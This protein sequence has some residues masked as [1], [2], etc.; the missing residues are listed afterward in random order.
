MGEMA[1]GVRSAELDFAFGLLSP[2]H[3]GIDASGLQQETI[4]SHR[5]SIIARAGHPLAAE[6]KASLAQLAEND[7]VILG[8]ERAMGPYFNE[9]F[10]SRGI[11]PPR[12]V[13]VARSIHLLKKILA[14]S[15]LISILATNAVTQEIARGEL[16]ILQNAEAAVLSETGFVSLERTFEAPAVKAMK[17]A[18]RDQCRVY[19]NGQ[20]PE[21]MKITA[22]STTRQRRKR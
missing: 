3:A 16:A 12:Q 9:T 19:F 18:L 15:D 6:R 2:P 10:I 8:P 7:W 20:S 5:T 14:G 17:Q 4:L 1:E 11:A 13:I 21:S 22:A